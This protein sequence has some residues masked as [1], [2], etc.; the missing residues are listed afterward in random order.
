MAP[1][2]FHLENVSFSKPNA[3]PASERSLVPVID[4]I[5][6]NLSADR[7]VELSTESIIVAPW[8]RTK[9]GQSLSWQ[10]EN[11][12]VFDGTSSI[13]AGTVVRSASDRSAEATVL[14][15]APRG[16]ASPATANP[17]RLYSI[18]VQKMSSI[19]GGFEELAWAET[20]LRYEALEP[21]R[22]HYFVLSRR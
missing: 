19:L 7:A 1:S 10:S 8:P 4:L 11:G 13:G 17:S 15:S 16:A 9:S 14:R 12:R 21:V 3:T 6:A 22:G 20:T 2:S 18:G 5:V